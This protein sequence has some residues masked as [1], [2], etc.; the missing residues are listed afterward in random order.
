[1]G[2]IKNKVVSSARARMNMTAQL[3]NNLKFLESNLKE[4]QNT[5]NKAKGYA[6]FKLP[7]VKDTIRRESDGIKK[8]TGDLKKLKERIRKL[9][10][11]GK[12]NKIL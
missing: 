2:T 10:K 4:R 5:L 11:E 7:G 12:I 9:Q 1:M 6:K 8:V 3:R